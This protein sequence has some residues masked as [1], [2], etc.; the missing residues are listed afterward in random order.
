MTPDKLLAT[1]FK[2]IGGWPDCPFQIGDILERDFENF[3]VW[4][5]PKLGLKS[6]TLEAYPS[7]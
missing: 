4:V 5:N 6:P 7:T 3:N 2:L 1:R